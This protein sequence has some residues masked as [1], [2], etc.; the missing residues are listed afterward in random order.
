MSDERTPPEIVAAAE[1]PEDALLAFIAQEL[2]H[3]GFEVKL[4]PVNVAR[5]TAGTATFVVVA[6]PTS[7]S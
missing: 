3:W 6:A 1:R 2:E 7:E 4:T 5:V